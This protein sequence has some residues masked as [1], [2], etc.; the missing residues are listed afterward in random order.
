MADARVEDAEEEDIPMA[1]GAMAMATAV[2]T[3]TATSI[4][5]ELE[6]GA[7]AANV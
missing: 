5:S 4:Y 2:F 7:P 1:K 6:I 3:I